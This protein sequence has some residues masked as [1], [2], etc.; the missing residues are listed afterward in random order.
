MT[1]KIINIGW[2]ISHLEF[3]IGDHYYFSKLK[4]LVKANGC[5]VN[6]VTVFYE[7]EFFDVIVLN[8]PEISF[9]DSEVDFL[10]QAVRSGKRVIIT[11]YYNN[12]DNISDTANSLCYK[13]GVRLN[14]DEIT[15]S[16][17]NDESDPLLPVISS[18][19]LFGESVSEL[20]LPC[21][22]SI[23]ITGNEARPFLLNNP[24][25]EKEKGVMGTITFAGKGEFILIGTCV[26]WD[27]YAISRYSNSIFSLNL[28]KSPPNK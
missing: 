1:N 16:E 8:Y 27:N 9:K 23:D 17:C 14:K 28:L 10:Y 4:S 6:E 12:E 21:C 7:L 25:A 15:N 5:S 20:L 22:A 19:D 11:G 3:T 26:F 18:I 24:H 2:D 13:F